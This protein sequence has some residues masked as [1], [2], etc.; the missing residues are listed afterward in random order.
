MSQETAQFIAL[1]GMLLD[2]RLVIAKEKVLK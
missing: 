1:E 2:C